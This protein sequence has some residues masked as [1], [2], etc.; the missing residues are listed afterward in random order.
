MY[1]EFATDPKVQMLSEVDQRRFVMLLC[2]RCSNGDVTLHDTEVAFQLRIS[3]E[4]WQE[5]KAILIAKNM[6][7]ESNLPT[8]WEKRQKRSDSSKDRV[9]RHRQRQKLDC[10]DECNVT[11]TVQIERE[12]E[13]ERKK[14]PPTPCEGAGADAPKTG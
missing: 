8:N 11:E 12:R 14:I 2:L 1:H 3:N 10:N 7:D 5:T 4:Q 6:I 9:F 13:R